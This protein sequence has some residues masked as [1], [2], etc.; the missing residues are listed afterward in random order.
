MKTIGEKIGESMAHIQKKFTSRAKRPDTETEVCQSDSRIV[1][2]VYVVALLGT[3]FGCI[4]RA[5]G[6]YARTELMAHA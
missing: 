2:Y 3:F 6:G 4:F 1:V 5:K